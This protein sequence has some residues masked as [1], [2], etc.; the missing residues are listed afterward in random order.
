MAAKYYQAVNKALS[1]FNLKKKL[2]GSVSFPDEDSYISPFIT[3][4]R[5]P[6]SGGAPIAK[7][8]ADKLNFEYVDDQ[9]VEE[10]AR[11]TKKRR[12][13]IK[14]I[15]EKSRSQIDDLVHSLLNVEYVGDEEY[16]IE[17]VRTIIAYAHK[18]H[19]V[20]LG[21]GANF[22]TPFGKGL[23]VNIV[24]P[25]VVRVRR[26]MDYEGLSERQAKD[27]IA[28]VEHER[29]EFVRQYFSS[30]IKQR[31]V[32]DLTL[33]TTFFSVNQARDVIIE[34]FKQKFS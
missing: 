30:N 32:F 13:I 2:E 21:R 24:A 8:L 34:A 33:N 31:N 17:L 28:K 23:H 11:S 6:G 4:A 18:G 15:D 12:A 19:C 9:I 1:Y 5:E 7:A 27:V 3:I 14:E 29:E 22:I 26:A 10:I 16:V 25:Y 20:I